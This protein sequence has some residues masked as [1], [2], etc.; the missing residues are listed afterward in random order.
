MVEGEQLKCPTFFGAR[1]CSSQTL[2]RL[3]KPITVPKED[4][5]RAGQITPAWWSNGG[6]SVEIDKQTFWHLCLEDEKKVGHN[7][8]LKVLNNEAKGL[9]WKDIHN[10]GCD[11]R[12]LSEAVK[13]ALKE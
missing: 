6:Y 4:V 12:D 9:V 10:I 1:R 3:G 13:K 11:V 2:L 8:V 7:A 5:A